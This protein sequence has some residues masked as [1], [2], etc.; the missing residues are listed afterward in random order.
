MY[1]FSFYSSLAALSSFI[2]CSDS[3]HTII[4][5]HH[6][7][8]TH[9]PLFLSNA[10]Q[11]DAQ[12]IELICGW[13]SLFDPQV[14]ALAA[15]RND[16]TSIVVKHSGGEA[17]APPSAGSPHDAVLHRVLAEDLSAVT[18]MV[19]GAFPV[20]VQATMLSAYG[21]GE[22]DAIITA[23]EY[24]SGV[25]VI[26]ESHRYST[27]ETFKVSTSRTAPAKAPSPA[28]PA[29]PTARSALDGTT[30]QSAEPS[31]TRSCGIAAAS[32]GAA[33][34]ASREHAEDDLYLHHPKYLLHS[35]GS[36]APHD[37]GSGTACCCHAPFDFSVQEP[38]SAASTLAPTTP[39]K[40][41]QCGAC[42]S[43]S[44]I[45]RDSFSKYT[46]SPRK[47]SPGGSPSDAGQ[48]RQRLNV[49][50]HIT[51]HNVCYVCRGIGDAAFPG[52][53]F[54][55]A[56]SAEMNYLNAILEDE[57]VP[58]IGTPH[59]ARLVERLIEWCMASVACGRRLQ[60]SHGMRLVVVGKGGFSAAVQERILKQCTT[61]DVVATVSKRAA[62]LELDAVLS[63]PDVDCV[64]VASP[65]S[66][67][68]DVIRT[69]L[70]FKKAVLCEQP[71]PELS[72]AL[73][74]ARESGCFLGVA[75][76]RRFA[77]KFQRAKDFL[78]L[79]GSDVNEVAIESKEPLKPV[80]DPLALVNKG[81]VNDVD[82]LAWLFDQGEAEIKID[83]IAFGHE[84]NGVTAR[85]T[86]FLKQYD[87]TIPARITY[88]R[89]SKHY[90]QTVSVNSRKFGYDQKTRDFFDV[91]E[92]AYLSLFNWTA[93]Q[94]LSRGR[95][96]AGYAAGLE[97]SQRLFSETLDK[98]RSEISLHAV[99]RHNE[100]RAKADAEQKKEEKLRKTRRLLA[101][102]QPQRGVNGKGGLF[103]DGERIYKPMLSETGEWG[104]RA[105]LKVV[106]PAL[107]E[108]TPKV[109]G[110]TVINGISYMVVKS[111][112]A[113]YLKPKVLDIKVGE[114]SDFSK[115]P[116]QPYG[117]RVVGYS[118]EAGTAR[119][120]S[121]WGDVLSA[122]KA[123][124]KDGESGVSRYEVIPQWVARLRELQR[125]TCDQT[126]LKFSNASLLFVYDST[127]T[128]PQKPNV[129]LSSLGK[130]M[131]TMETTETTE[132]VGTVGTVGTMKT[133]ETMVEGTAAPAPKYDHFFSFG[134]QN[135]ID[136]LEEIHKKFTQRHAIFLCRH[137]FRIDYTDLNW[138]PSAA[139][140]HDPPLSREG[141]RQAQDL[142]KRLKTENIDVIVSSPFGRAMMTA[143][144]VAEELN[145]RYVVEPALAEFLSTYNRK[146]VPSLDPRFQEDPRIDKG[147]KKV[148]KEI[149]LE[150]WESM[151]QRATEA[152]T[153]IMNKYRRVAIVS[154]RFFFFF[155]FSFLICFF[156]FLFIFISLFVYVLFAFSLSFPLI[157]TSFVHFFF[158]PFHLSLFYQ[159]IHS[160]FHSFIRSFS[161]FNKGCIHFPPI[162][163]QYF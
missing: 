50:K 132:K 124:I 102:L 26:I 12:N 141:V 97:R 69:A 28:S 72:D 75:S 6:A 48:P 46:R 53:R 41:G 135:L 19:G 159:S 44:P 115:L 133:T 22:N 145:V 155:P 126:V 45:L 123:F 23:L 160:F 21:R 107:R 36:W 119:G 86:V 85:Y 42:F 32:K 111:V 96:G 49:V 118:D 130:T 39:V 90:V 73:R 68:A 18:A 138:V 10:Q 40:A 81:V 99:E 59:H 104:L 4:S 113:R 51:S 87:K 25:S 82:T 20:S 139:Y 151:C 60:P 106:F 2:A 140:P 52:E 98:V 58:R 149:T 33:G 116:T 137:G 77:P 11:C 70:R 94:V 91:Y 29:P 71:V 62:R 154:H 105:R 156:F 142:A 3:Y 128:M 14:N 38:L 24:E 147:Y 30:H 67:R 117:L 84:G 76:Q 129:Y 1:R 8:P 83:S 56:Q 37:F 61:C 101:A 66:T 146:A 35:R 152:V 65:R 134:L 92:D 74:L 143:K 136:I 31:V 109:Y 17:L 153:K 15:K 43:S 5:L 144:A 158:P 157:L 110:K 78:T 54:S 127:D 27:K 114:P 161:L 120:D 9:S 89:C 63:R 16:L 95:G 163:S 121:S 103:T 112:T 55:Q 88:R 131:E 80:D 47:T 64:Y 13:K 57:D 150:S 125:I 93:M 34:C 108:F 7:T 122:F 79:L 100:W 148:G 162:Y